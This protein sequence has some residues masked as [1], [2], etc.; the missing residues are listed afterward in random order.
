MYK[1]DNNFTDNDATLVVKK[2]WITYVGA[3]FY[4][5]GIGAVVQYTLKMLLCA[6]VS[7]VVFLEINEGL[8]TE[9]HSS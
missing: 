6:F 7:T 4:R 5:H 1:E 3:D 2:N 8:Y 9:W